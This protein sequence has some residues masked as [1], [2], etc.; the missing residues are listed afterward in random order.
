MSCLPREY[1][2]FHWR[3][4]QV[5]K[6]VSEYFTEILYFIFFVFIKCWAVAELHL[7]LRDVPY[8]NNFQ[9]R[10]GVVAITTGQLHSTNLELRFCAGS[11]LARD[12]SEIRDGEDLWQCSRMEIRLKACRQSTIPQK[13]FVII[14]INEK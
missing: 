7:A 13:Q 14:I 2:S 8:V 10:R 6:L 5:S 3:L 12:M 1:P 11:N 4:P 9:W